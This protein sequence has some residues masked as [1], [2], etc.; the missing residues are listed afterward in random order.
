MRKTKKIVGGI[1][2]GFVLAVAAF[3]AVG[4][5]TLAARAATSAAQDQ[6]L[7]VDAAGKVLVRG[8][9]SAITANTVTV[10]SWGGEWTAN[11]GADTQILPNITG[12]D[13]AKF[14]VGDYV[15]VQGTVRQDAAWSIDATLVRDWT[16]RTVAAAEQKQNRASASQT[17]KTNAPKNY[18]GIAGA[19]SSGAFALTVGD[20]VNSVEVA[21]DAEIVN[22]NWIAIPLEHIREGDTVRVWGVNASGTITAKIVRD[23]SIPATSTTP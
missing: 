15:G 21:P 19:M 20:V 7:R 5:M 12:N 3:V 16:Y 9:V 13:F 1:A 2:G 8:T 22:R 23:V 4:M 18:V 14:Q 10:K 17:M 11:V 6:V